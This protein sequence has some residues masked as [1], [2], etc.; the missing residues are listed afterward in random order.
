MATTLTSK[1]LDFFKPDPGNPRKS[2]NPEELREL[3]DSL[4]QEAAGAAAGEAGRHHH[5]R[6]AAVVRGQA[7]RQAGTPRC[8]HHR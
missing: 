4:V 2:F 3:H 1:P 6:V 8:H 5:R 7:G